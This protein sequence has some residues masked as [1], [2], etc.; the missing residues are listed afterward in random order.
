[1][2]NHFYDRLSAM[3]N[4]F[5]VAETP[6]TPMHVA[7]IEIFEAG[8][9]RA[10]EGGI[11]I[12]RIRAAYLGVMHQIPRYRQK[13]QWIPF[14]NRPV[15]VD[16]PHFNIDYHVRHVSLP[17]PGTEAD[18]RRVASRVLANHLDRRR[19]LWEIWVVEGLE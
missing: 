16:D 9:L 1:M 14:E 8:P 13:L 6:T 4:T 11:D 12:E 2:A 17:L 7:A 3:D 18:L 5:L 10:Q 19:P 15:W